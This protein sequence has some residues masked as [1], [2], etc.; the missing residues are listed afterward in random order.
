MLKLTVVKE[1]MLKK[2]CIF[3]LLLGKKLIITGLAKRKLY[4]MK[5]EM[6]ALFNPN[7]INLKEYLLLHGGTTEI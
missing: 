5:T 4:V 1:L 3:Y 7:S 6:N 2:S